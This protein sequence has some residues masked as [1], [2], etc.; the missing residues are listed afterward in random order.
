MSI[1]QYSVETGQ[2][3]T[4]EQ[5]EEIER[6][7]KMPF[8]YDEDCPPLTEEQLKRFRRVNPPATIVS[9]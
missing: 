9:N 6:A 4:P 5:I 3:P 8:V 7:A 2:Q 1:V